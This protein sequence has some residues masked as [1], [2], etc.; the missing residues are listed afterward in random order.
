M[1]SA[2]LH[3]ELAFSTNEMDRFTTLDR[4]VVCLVDFVTADRAIG[5]LN[6]QCLLLPVIGLLMTLVFQ[7]EFL[8]RSTRSLDPVSA[9]LGGED[10][11]DIRF[12]CSVLFSGRLCLCLY[13]INKYLKFLEKK[14]N[15][16]SS[17]NKNETICLF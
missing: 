17:L 12:V 3:L 1:E 14:I 6:N 4:V 15:N 9:F 8:F 13:L 10:H 2:F 16:N 5:C 11:I 7:L